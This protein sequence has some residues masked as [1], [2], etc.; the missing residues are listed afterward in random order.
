[1]KGNARLSLDKIAV[2]GA[3]MT[4]TMVAIAIRRALPT[5]DITLIE[6][7]DD[8]AAV[9]DRLPIATATTRSVLA[10]IGLDETALIGGGHATHKLGTR[11]LDWR[12]D[13]APWVHGHGE[14]GIAVA[15]GA[16]HQHWLQ[17]RR[18]GPINAFHTYSPAATLA[19]ADRYMP[20]GDHGEVLL[21]RHDH[22]VR[23][24]P[25]TVLSLLGQHA[26]TLN[27]RRIVGQIAA[28]ERDADGLV[29]L[30][31]LDQNRHITADLFIDCTGPQALLRSR[32]D[33]DFEDWGDPCDRVL[34]HQRR[35]DASPCDTFQA[36]DDGWRATIRLR[37][38]AIEL[39]GYASAITAE[40]QARATFSGDAQIITVRAGRRT[41]WVA[42]VVALGDAATA[43]GALATQGFALT[44]ADLDLLLDLLPGRPIAEEERREYN[45][46]SM[47]RSSLIHDFIALH[48]LRSTRRK[49]AFWS[50]PRAK[51][52]EGLGL[53]LAQFDRR[54]L[55]P[56]LE[57]TIIGRDDWLAV[58]LGLGIMP[59]RP[60]PVAI[61]AD[62]ARMRVALDRL[63]MAVAALPTRLPPYG[64]WLTGR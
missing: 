18:T 47:L 54:G 36:V 40:D 50:I 5:A 38:R 19:D 56:R 13:G 35:S 14:T 34:I 20:P 44:L 58:L 41:P 28:V 6:T 43:T 17:A 29:E 11:F 55:V 22:A 33:A 4:G 23:L 52:P 2:L 15:P 21:E 9:S 8:P 31:A 53:L 7:P 48:T 27:I 12:H 39:L 24:D 26:G 60:D 37:D 30:L 42:N 45:R 10:R 59:E 46:R 32:L 49:G 1:M 16:F 62:A 64:A 57:E 25:S 51:P 61:G 63:H 3:G